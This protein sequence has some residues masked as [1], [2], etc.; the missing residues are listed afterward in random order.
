MVMIDLM[1]VRIL[2]HMVQ[3]VQCHNQQDRDKLVIK[4]F[5]INK[6]NNRS[7]SHLKINHF[8]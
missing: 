7:L 5:S 8:A 4:R 1:N 6:M 2:I 3:K